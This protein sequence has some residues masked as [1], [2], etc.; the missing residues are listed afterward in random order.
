MRLALDQMQGRGVYPSV[1]NNTIKNYQPLLQK[2]GNFGYY[3]EANDTCVI[4][5]SCGQ[6]VTTYYGKGM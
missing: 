6:V 2:N 4:L 3:D 1:V 5:N